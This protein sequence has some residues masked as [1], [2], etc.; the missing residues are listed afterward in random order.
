M[1]FHVRYRAKLVRARIAQYEAAL[2][3]VLALDTAHCKHPPPDSV[4]EQMYRCE[5]YEFLPDQFKH[6]AQGIW[7]RRSSDGPEAFF[8]IVRHSRWLVI[9]ASPQRPAIDEPS[10]YYA[11]GN[12]W[13]TTLPPPK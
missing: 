2:P 8:A 7:V 5:L 6:L 9:H 4:D 13:R 12:G 11:L 3:I 10:Y 1:R